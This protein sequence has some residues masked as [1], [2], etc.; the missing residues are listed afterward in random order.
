MQHY[1]GWKQVKS[2]VSKP[3]TERTGQTPLICETKPY[4]I[5]TQYNINS[6]CLLGINPY[7]FKFIFCY[8]SNYVL[9]HI[10]VVV[11][12]LWASWMPLVT[13]LLVSL[14]TSNNKQLQM[15]S[16]K[17]LTKQNNVQWKLFIFWM[18]QQFSSCIPHFL[19]QL[20]PLWYYYPSRMHK[21]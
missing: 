13:V 19:N 8:S 16:C 10:P 5:I 12:L 1:S 7:S 17:I 9:L 2:S 11:T 20:L 21:G 14:V 4:D 18:S 6:A 3:S 15:T